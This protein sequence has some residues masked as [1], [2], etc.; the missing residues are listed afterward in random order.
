MAYIDYY[1]V[2]GIDKKASAEEIRKAYRKLARKYHPD[3][4]PDNAAAKIKFQ[5][6]NEANEVLSDPEKRKTKARWTFVT[7]AWKHAI[8]DPIRTNLVFY[9]TLRDYHNC[10]PLRI[11]LTARYRRH[12]EYFGLR[13]L[14]HY[15]T[16]LSLIGTMNCQV[17]CGRR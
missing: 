4:N 12:F 11:F 6:V 2:L 16:S 13:L 3:V 10:G 1:G 7:T 8:A 14:Q 9:C 15:I 17:A 5:Q